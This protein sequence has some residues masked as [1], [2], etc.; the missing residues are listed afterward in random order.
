MRDMVSVASEKTVNR[1]KDD[2]HCEECW[3]YT[4]QDLEGKE[5]RTTSVNACAKWKV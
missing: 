5:D 2:V 3:L 4:N 1:E